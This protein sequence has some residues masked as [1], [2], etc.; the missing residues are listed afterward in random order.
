MAATRDRPILDGMWPH[1]WYGT[2]ACED[3]YRDVLTE[4]E[5][6]GAFG[7]RVALGE[8]WHVNTKGDHAYVVVPASM[9]LKLRVQYVNQ[10]DSVFRLSLRK[11][12]ESGA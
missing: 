11:V 3:W 5:H 7:Y 4:G 9:I 2:T 1:V 10:S 8:P 12:D 6:V